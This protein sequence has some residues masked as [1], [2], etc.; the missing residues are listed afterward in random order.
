[1][2]SSNIFSCYDSRVM[3]DES[4]KC[5]MGDTYKFCNSLIHKI[6]LQKQTNKN[7]RLL[8]KTSIRIDRYLLRKQKHPNTFIRKS[9]ILSKDIHKVKK[10]VRKCGKIICKKDLHEYDI[11]VLT[12]KLSKRYQK[13]GYNDIIVMMLKH[14]L[15][16]ERYYLKHKHHH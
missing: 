3:V 1:M 14:Q 16:H 5:C 12:T 10:L 13:N 11:P 2:D 9:R 4:S 8:A 7:L 6:P 15:P